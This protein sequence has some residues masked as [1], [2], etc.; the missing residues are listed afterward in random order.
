[1]FGAAKT[2]TAL[3]HELCA[4]RQEGKLADPDAFLREKERLLKKLPQGSLAGWA[5][6][7]LVL[8]GMNPLIVAAISPNPHAKDGQYHSYEELRRAVVATVG[9]NNIMLPNHAAAPEKPV[10]QRQGQQQSNYKGPQSPRY[11]PYPKGNAN[12][13]QSQAQPQAKKTNDGAGPSGSKQVI[14]KWADAICADCGHPGHKSKGFK[15]CPKHV[16][17]GQFQKDD[18]GKAKA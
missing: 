10:W 1:M 9:L 11:A 12:K 3:L 13:Q 15:D 14:G 4:V 6:A 18:K 2:P 5:Q 8:M 17:N 16:P 7:S